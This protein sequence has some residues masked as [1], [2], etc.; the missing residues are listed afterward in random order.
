MNETVEAQ[1]KS[2]IRRLVKNKNAFTIEGGRY[3]SIGKSLIRIAAN[4]NVITYE[5]G[6]EE[7]T[8]D[9]FNKILGYVGKV[10]KSK[11]KIVIPNV[12]EMSRGVTIAFLQEVKAN[13]NG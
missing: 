2:A 10:T 9:D 7:F 6:Y 4:N 5:G 3:E 12:S 11:A 13:E 1:I 8:N